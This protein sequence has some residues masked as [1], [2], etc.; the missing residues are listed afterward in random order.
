MRVDNLVRI[1]GKNP[2]S[3]LKAIGYLLKHGVLNVCL[4]G[5]GRNTEKTIIVALKAVEIFGLRLG[6]IQF[7]PVQHPDGQTIP[8]LEISLTGTEAIVAPTSSFLA[9]EKLFL[10]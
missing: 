7:G 10:E 8:N 9:F 3:Y 2:T 5:R 1:G 4:V 6:K